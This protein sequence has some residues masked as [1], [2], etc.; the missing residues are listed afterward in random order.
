MRKR[1]FWNSLPAKMYFP[2][3]FSMVEKVLSSD[4]AVWYAVSIVPRILPVGVLPSF[5]LSPVSLKFPFLLFVFMDRSCSFSFLIPHCWLMPG[6][7]TPSLFCG[8]CWCYNEKL[9]LDVCCDNCS[10]GSRTAGLLFLSPL[11]WLAEDQW[12]S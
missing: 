7:C 3:D 1:D 6:V 4:T 11:S 10:L 8:R 5:L 12:A 2:C 9:R